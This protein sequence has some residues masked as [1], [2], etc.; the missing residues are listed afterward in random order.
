LRLDC[1]FILKLHITIY[2][3]KVVNS[4]T[5]H[6]GKTISATPVC[7]TKGSHNLD[8][9]Y[10]AF[11][12]ITKNHYMIRRFIHVVVNL[13]YQ[14]TISSPILK[15]IYVL[16]YTFFFTILSSFVNVVLA[17]A[18]SLLNFLF[19]E[20]SF[21]SRKKKYLRGL[22]NCKVEG[23]TELR[24]TNLK[25]QFVQYQSSLLSVFYPN[26]KF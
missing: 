24:T 18:P 26:I 16:F 22:L 2:L 1:C 8:T 23:L 4:I 20:D 14:F 19:N 25:Y 11:I 3:M 15:Q 7:C 5:F 21:Y 17:H 10:Y 6:A 12:F 13:V 9:S